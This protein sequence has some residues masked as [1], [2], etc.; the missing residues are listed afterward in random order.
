MSY[1]LNISSDDRDSTSDPTNNFTISFSPPMVIPQNWEIALQQLNVWYSWFNISPQYNNQ[2]F[3]YSTNSGGTFKT[4]TITAGL[5]TL[6]DI[7]N[8]IQAQMLAN[9]DYNNSTNPPSFYVTLSAD[10]NTFKCLI[11]ITNATYQ[12][13]LTQGNLY[14]LLGFTPIIVTT[15]QEGANIVN[16]TNG[17]DK[18][19]AHCDIVTGSYSGGSASDV[20]YAFQANS[21]PSSLMEFT[22]FKLIYLPISVAN[23]LYKMRLYLTDQDGN[24]L[25][26]NGE[27]INYTLHLRPIKR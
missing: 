6:Q 17:I 3:R 15:T 25:D 4:I 11:T 27:S 20:I 13:D 9:G 8:Y 24:N 19:Y 26:L 22:P 21:A 5:Y 1:L 16:I 7:N 12:V 23:Y 2:T 10:Y 18:I 14:S